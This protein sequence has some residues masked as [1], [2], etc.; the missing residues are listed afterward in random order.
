MTGLGVPGLDAVRLGN[1]LSEARDIETER[2]FTNA[3][4]KRRCEITSQ[5]YIT[6]LI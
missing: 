4:K 5:D 2:R 1:L 6:K 3:S